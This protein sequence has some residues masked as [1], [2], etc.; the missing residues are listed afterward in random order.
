VR[1]RVLFAV[2]GVLALA[3]ALASVYR[4]VAAVAAY[5]VA[6][7][8]DTPP[9]LEAPNEPE[10]VRWFDDYYTVE[11]IDAETVAIGEPR[12]WQ[13]NYSYLIL[14]GERAVLFDSG[15]GVRSIRAVV[16]SLTG[17]P[18]TL[19]P[20]H[21]HY[22]HVGDH[23][24]FEGVAIIDLPQLRE[25]TRGG[26]LVPTRL[27][28]LGWLEGFERP[29][30]RV[31]E[32][33]APDSVVD[34]GGRE[35]RVLHTPGH[36]PESASLYDEARGQLFSGDYLYDGILLAFLPGS[37]LADYLRTAE[38][39]ASRLPASARILSGHRA[40]PPGAPVLEL[41]HL[42]DLRRT[43]RDIRAGTAEGAGLVPRAFRVNDRLELWTDLPWTEA[44]E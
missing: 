25:R 4:R 38:R 42:H 27:E 44:W 37:S 12:F 18:V 28:H 20:S 26:V 43:L 23:G 16:E 8:F 21:L 11:F 9:L 17:L 14:G 24:S 10:R 35:L 2:V 33:W 41:R 30:L 39:L 36:T 22:D 32:W 5:G 29:S 15:P 13:Q 40:T 19:F 6:L 3:L 31:T 1:L 7:A 34:L